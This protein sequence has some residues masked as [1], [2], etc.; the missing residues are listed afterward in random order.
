MN[1]EQY[2][3]FPKHWVTSDI[4]FSHLNII[5]YQPEQRGH[6]CDVEEMNEE[7]VRRW[8]ETVGEGDHTFII[9]DVA[10][11]D[12]SKAPGYLRRMNGFKTLVVGNHDR[13]LMKLEGIKEHFISFSDYLCFAPTKGTGIVM[14]H[15]PIA[16]WD[17]K[18][19][20]NTSSIHLHGHLHGSPSSLFGWFHDVGMDT[21][22]LR[23]YNLEE[24]VKQIKLK[25]PG[26][27]N[28]HKEES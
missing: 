2:K 7:I 1:K 8:N 15:Y 14:M 3:S 19:P 17:G 10:M 27:S 5:K 12:V 13:S 23:P 22:D 6:F 24:L 9:G 25:S 20:N 21:N 4:H 11:G 18:R 28:H 26:S 16:S